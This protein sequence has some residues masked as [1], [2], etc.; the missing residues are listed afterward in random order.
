M[1]TNGYFMLKQKT[2]EKKDAEALGATLDPKLFKALGEP[3]RIRIL[4]FLIING[5]SDISAIAGVLPQDRSVISRHLNLMYEAGLLVGEKKSRHMFYEVN[6]A[7]L[8]N[9]LKDIQEKIIQCM[10]DC[11]DLSNLN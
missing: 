9:K 3:I 7:Y 10:P 1:C 8:L 4:K 5:R 11:G 2:A 6:G